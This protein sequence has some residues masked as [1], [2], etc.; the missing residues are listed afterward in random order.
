MNHEI[1]TRRSYK[2]IAQRISTK[3]G[4]FVFSFQFWGLILIKKKSKIKMKLL[5]IS[6]IRLRFTCI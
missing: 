3:T 6:Q 2:H 4:D 1:G 5:K